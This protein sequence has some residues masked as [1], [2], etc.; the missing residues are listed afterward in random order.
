MVMQRVDR[1]DVGDALDPAAF[2]HKV[3]PVINPLRRLL[4]GAPLTCSSP[5]CGRQAV[6]LRGGSRGYGLDPT[7][8]CSL[9]RLGL[10]ATTDGA[11]GKMS[12]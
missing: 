6:T 4:D 12:T 10:S 3:R 7:W 5:S 8:L 9:E 11:G 2:Q 1:S